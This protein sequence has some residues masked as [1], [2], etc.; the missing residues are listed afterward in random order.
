[1]LR[2]GK[3]AHIPYLGFLRFL[4]PGEHF[5]LAPPFSFFYILPSS[6]TPVIPSRLVIEYTADFFPIPLF[7]DK[8]FWPRVDLSPRA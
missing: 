4:E 7:S 2:S 3:L 1:M 5:H 6:S 8:V